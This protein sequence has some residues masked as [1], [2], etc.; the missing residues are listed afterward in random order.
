MLIR[1]VYVVCILGAILAVA[2][3][4]DL[5]KDEQITIE[6]GERI[7]DLTL[8][9]A[10]LALIVVL[11][12]FLVAVWLLKQIVDFF[13]WALT[14]EDV[15]L[16]RWWGM[17]RQRSGLDA[18]A[19]GR[20]A[21]AAGDVK[22]AARKAKVAERRLKRPDLTRLL[23]AEVAEAAGDQARANSYYRALMAEDETAF[24]GAKGLLKQ[25]LAGDDTDK[26]LK[27]ANHA[28]ELNPKDGET[29]EALY[30]LQSQK[31]DWAG[32]RKTVEQQMRAGALPKPEANKRSAALALAQA[33]DAERVGEAEH[34]RALAVE[35]AKLDLGNVT[36]VS[37]AVKHLVASGSKRAAT[38]LVIDAWQVQPHP[39]LAAAFA[40]I[41]PDEA[42]A[43]RRRRF[44]TL[45]QLQSDHSEVRFLQAELALVAEDWRGARTAIENLRETE[46]SARSCAIMA[47]IARGEGEPDHIVRGWLARAL[48]APRG[49][50]GDS[51]ISH[52]A[53]LPLLI[54]QPQHNAGD[55]SATDPDM[56]AS[57]EDEMPDDV[58]D[59][60][61]GDAA[62]DDPSV[63][64][65]VSEA[66]VVR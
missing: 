24:V 13:R 3:G 25:A 1:I 44:E 50:G 22:T 31:F 39:Q 40:S 46:P 37:T 32:A 55:N 43:A 26:A 42:P 12:A 10:A 60:T 11:I 61:T 23:N 52:A 5:L 28:N 2:L 8:F 36:A 47:A 62:Q 65:D 56:A 30:T 21:L 7:Y 58:A 63:K 33:E 6:Y 20:I 17:S 64:K 41:E 49:E 57:T 15:S 45:F 19:K 29:L 18:L 14:G 51:A 9:E 53:M 34:A 35:A 38:K 16:G 66:E 27:L 4:L 48:G 59:A 54:E